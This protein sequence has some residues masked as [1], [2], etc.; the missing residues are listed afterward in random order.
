M[1]VLNYL[2]PQQIVRESYSYKSLGKVGLVYK[3]SSV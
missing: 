2:G 3:I 1:W